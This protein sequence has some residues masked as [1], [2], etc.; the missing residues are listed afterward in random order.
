MNPIR[1]FSL[2]AWMDLEEI[3]EHIA[4]DSPQNAAEMVRQI[5]DSIEHLKTF[6]KRTIV[7]GQPAGTKNP[8]RSLPVKP[9]IIFFRVLEEQ[10]IVRILRVR[11]GS[12]RRLGS[13][14][15]IRP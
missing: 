1:F 14:G 13:R 11:H 2:P 12:R 8:I 7:S 5:L 4:R 6:P 10:R 15:I 9:Y 3:A